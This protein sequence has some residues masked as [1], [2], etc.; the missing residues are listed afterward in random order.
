MDGTGAFFDPLLQCLPKEDTA[1][2]VRYPRSKILA[3]SEYVNFIAEHLPLVGQYILVGESFSGP[4]AIEIAKRKP[5]RMAGV[6]LLTT[7]AEPP[8]GPIAR[9]FARLLAPLLI[10]LTPPAFAVRHFMAGAEASDAQVMQIQE[11][12]RSTKAKV[13]RSRLRLILEC[14]AL[15]MLHEIKLPA[16]AIF[17]GKD[18]LVPKECAIGISERAQSLKGVEID[19]PHLLAYMHPREVAKALTEFQQSMKP[20]LKSIP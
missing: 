20:A 6:V 17:A 2:V 10:G 5:N 12:L 3:R 13:L 19:G 7:F 18:R 8:V 1:V 15:E 14:D 9:F 11:T 16:L 4:F